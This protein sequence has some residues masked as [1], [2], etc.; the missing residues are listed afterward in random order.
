M[1]NLLE[2]GTITSPYGK[3]KSPTAGASSNHK[4][5]DIVLKDKNVPAVLGGTVDFAGYSSSAGNYIKVN[6]TDGTTATYMHLDSLKVKTGDSVSTGQIIGVEGSTG[7]STG[8]H[9]HFQVEKDG[10]TLDPEWYFNVGYPSADNA[11]I[12]V[13]D[14]ETGVI[15]GTLLDIAGKLL[16][17]V[18]VVL[19]VVLAAYLFMKAFNISII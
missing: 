14:S 2:R 10:A 16:T 4:G 9:L 15:K 18:V 5:I 3:R 19:I 1:I 17:F 6:Q 8:S 11:E 13:S 12:G 7:I